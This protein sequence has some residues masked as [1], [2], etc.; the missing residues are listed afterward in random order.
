MQSLDGITTVCLDSMDQQLE[1][2]LRGMIRAERSRR[3]RPITDSLGRVTDEFTARGALRHGRYPVM[4]DLETAKEY[5]WRADKWLGIVQRAVNETGLT[6]TAERARD[7]QSV[8][9]SELVTDTNELIEMLGQKA[10]GRNEVRTAELEEAK[11]RSR[12]QLSHELELLVFAQ[13]RTRVPIAEQLCAPRYAAVEAAWKKAMNLLD[14]PTP[15]YS[16]AAKEAVGTVE[17]LARIV[18]GK[19]TATLGDSIKDLRISSRIEAPLLKGIEELWG[20]ASVTPGVRHGAGTAEV[21]AATAQYAVSLAEAAL[22]L[23]L[24]S[25]AA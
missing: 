24:A 19:P 18:V 21:N 15:D 25:D 16:N 13:D 22:G 1:T 23:L 10:F 14:S 17:Q 7:T 2:I 3:A 5:E 8:I 6:W 11:D 4:L 20:W 12:A 9:E